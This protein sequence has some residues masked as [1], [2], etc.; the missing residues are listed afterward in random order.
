VDFLLFQKA[1]VFSSFLLMTDSII[2]M[3]LVKNDKSNCK[4]SRGQRRKIWPTSLDSSISSGESSF[5]H[6]HVCALAVKRSRKE[7]WHVDLSLLIKQK[8]NGLFLSGD[9][10]RA[11][12]FWGLKV[13]T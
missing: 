8:I 5:D 2:L 1:L 3:M 12:I 9:W 10:K 13:H 6:V 11:V 4:R 7:K